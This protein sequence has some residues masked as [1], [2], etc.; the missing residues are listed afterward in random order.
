MAAREPIQTLVFL[1]LETSGLIGQ[2]D[3]HD[4]RNPPPFRAGDTGR[5]VQKIFQSYAQSEYYH[6]EELHGV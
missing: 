1:D 2:Y 3:R 5:D 6:S 4:P